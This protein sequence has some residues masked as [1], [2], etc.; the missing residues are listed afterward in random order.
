MNRSEIEVSVYGTGETYALP[1]DRSFSLEVETISAQDAAYLAGAL[2]GGTAVQISAT[3][4]TGSFIVTEFTVS[5]PLDDVVS[6][7]ATLKRTFNA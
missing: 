3:N 5:E 1:G 6:Y 7:T 2:E 4:V